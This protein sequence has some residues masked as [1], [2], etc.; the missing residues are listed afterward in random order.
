MIQI[1]NLLSAFGICFTAFSNEA[2]P[3]ADARVNT[4]PHEETRQIKVT[5]PLLILPDAERF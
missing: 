3:R 4:G 2:C 1:L 5:E